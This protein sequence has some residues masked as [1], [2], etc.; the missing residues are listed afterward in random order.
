MS[1][2]K[3]CFNDLFTDLDEE[4]ICETIEDIKK[5]LDKSE[6]HSLRVISIEKVEE[7]QS[8]FYDPDVEQ[9][10]YLT[11][12]EAIDYVNRNHDHYTGRFICGM[13]EMNP[14]LVMEVKGET[15]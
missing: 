15:K 10:F 2:Y 4:H 11:M 12:D 7:G 8:L 13:H 9:C 6:R 1:N 3:V 14:C 5:Y